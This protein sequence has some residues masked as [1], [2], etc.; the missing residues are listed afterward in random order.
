MQILRKVITFLTRAK[1]IENLGRWKREDCVVKTSIK[2][3]YANLDHCGPCGIQ[4]V[5]RVAKQKE[6][7]LQK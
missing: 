7:S 2:V 5:I 6:D 4:D 1:P 3:D